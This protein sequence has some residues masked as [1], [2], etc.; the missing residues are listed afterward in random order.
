MDAGRRRF[1]LAGAGAAGALAVGGGL[2]AADVLP[3]GRRLRDLL[4]DDGPDT[5]IPDRAPGPRAEGSF[6]SDR[7]G[8]RDTRWIVSYPPGSSADADLPVVVVL[9]GKGGDADS[10]FD[11]LGLDRFLAD[12]TA[13]GMAPIAV[14]SVDGGD[15]YWH[16][17]QDGSDSGAMV[18]DELLP[19][20]AVRGLRTDRLGLLGWSM[21]GYGSLR[22][23][24]DR[25]AEVAAVAT[26]SAAI[27]RRWED[28]SPGAFDDAED[29]ARHDLFAAVDRLDDVP[30]RMACGT[31]DPFIGGNRALADQLT[32]AATSFGAGDHRPGYW[33]TQVPAHL[34]FLAAQITAT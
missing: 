31:N 18:T 30:I 14:A 3:G 27:W 20:L 19:L 7:R 11:D 2:V 21:G 29:F 16:P 22:L 1:L 6:R 9:H 17:R 34:R 10:A 25:P 13:A 33:R 4:G 15:T 12:E 26:S 23:A 5:P 32:G 8:G 24:A 28:S